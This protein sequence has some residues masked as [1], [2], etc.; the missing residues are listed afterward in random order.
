M[1]R[2]IAHQAVLLADM[3]IACNDAQLQHA[4]AFPAKAN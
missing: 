4:R 1:C 3:M 2:L